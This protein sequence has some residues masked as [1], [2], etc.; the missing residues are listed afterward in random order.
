LESRYLYFAILAGSLLVPFLLSFDRKV[1]FYRRWKYLFPAMIPP[2]LF[3]IAWDM[4]FT[5]Q[6]VW[7]FNPKFISGYHIGNL[8]VEEVLF[9]FVVPYCCMFIYECIRVYFRN[10]KQQS[11]D[12]RILKVMS[13]LL[14]LTGIIFYDR[15]YTSW[16][17]ILCGL[18]IQVIYFFRHFFRH[19]D[20]TLFIISYSV[21]L[22]PF[23]VVNGVL[24]SMP[25]V[26]YNHSENLDLR[27]WRIPVEDVFYGMLLILMNVV[28]YEKLKSRRRTRTT[29][30]SDGEQLHGSE[31]HRRNRSRH[32]SSW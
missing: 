20:A 10:L 18:F 32:R 5:Q 1:Q 4:Y 2:A 12:E 13:V 15:M 31:H 29:R 11:R 25:V 19:F 28:I 17:F 21:I 23:L 27:I 14:L 26:I 8:P 16:T 7:D 30:G 3:Y 9:F 24:T 6:K 22:V